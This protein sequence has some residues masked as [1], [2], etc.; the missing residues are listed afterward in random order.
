MLGLNGLVVKAHGNSTAL[1]MKNAILQCVA[2]HEQNLSG[3]IQEA[4][5]TK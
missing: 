3:K 1:Q 2:Y 4:L 5:E